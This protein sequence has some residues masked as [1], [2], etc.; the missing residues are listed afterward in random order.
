MQISSTVRMSSMC[1]CVCVCVEG[2]VG[3]EC[4]YISI[5]VYICIHYG[6]YVLGFAYETPVQ[7]VTDKLQST[8]RE[9]G[10]PD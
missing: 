1:V 2:G 6:K 9:A 7:G 5:Y 10:W 4:I 8:S 3:G